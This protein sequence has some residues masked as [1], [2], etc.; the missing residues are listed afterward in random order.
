MDK[1]Y[2]Q[3]TLVKMAGYRNRLT[4][5]YADVTPTEIYRIVTKDLDDFKP[6]LEAIRDL[7]QNPEKFGLAL[8]A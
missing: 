3:T 7:V 8:E 4:H 2:A 1:D 5:F 6:F